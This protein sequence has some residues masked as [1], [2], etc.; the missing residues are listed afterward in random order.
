MKRFFGIAFAAL[1]IC[2]MIAIFRFSSQSGFDTNV[3]SAKF[4]GKIASVL[5]ENYD[6]MEPGIKQIFTNEL[7]LFVRK[8]AHFSLYF[9][10]GFAFF[11]FFF[12]ILKRNWISGVL[13]IGICFIY[14]L[15]DEFH[16]SFV[17]GRT[18]LVKDI[19]I[20]TAGSWAGSLFCF[21]IIA[22]I[23]YAADCLRG[24]VFKGMN[25][26]SVQ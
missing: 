2:L 3:M 5:F 1:G 17:P 9:L 4:T 20:D 14:A 8:A 22:A 26:S 13:S 24:T 23:K 15:T 6:T 18:P 10:T 25:N 16:Q 12:S 11:A 21:I 19:F 7:N